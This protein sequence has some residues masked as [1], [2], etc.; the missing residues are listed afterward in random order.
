MGFLGSLLGRSRVRA[1]RPGRFSALASAAG[2]MAGRG[3][4]RTGRRAGVLFNPETGASIPDLA[5]ELRDAVARGGTSSGT[6]VEVEL[7]EF[8]T[9]WIILDNPDF[10]ALIEALTALNETLFGRGNGDRLLAA[11]TGMDYERRPAYLIYNYK[12]GRFYP[13]V[14]S[15]DGEGRDNE[16]ELRLGG[17]MER[18]RVDIE[19][20]LE[21]WYGLSGIPF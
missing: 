13:L 19:P 1:P 14:R 10:G 3:E 5:A 4:V 7:D 12:R 15:A 17:L 18:G 21:H 6:R 20:S 8:E 16:A 11:V 9:G 2:E